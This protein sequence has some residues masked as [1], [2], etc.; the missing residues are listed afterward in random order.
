MILS[1][2]GIGLP[3]AIRCWEGERQSPTKIGREPG[4]NLFGTHFLSNLSTHPN[5]KD[6]YPKTGNLNVVEEEEANIFHYHMY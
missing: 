1:L 3:A 4:Y 6:K 2:V 5:F